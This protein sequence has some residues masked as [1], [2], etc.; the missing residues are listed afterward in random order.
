MQVFFEKKDLINIK[1]SKQYCKHKNKCKIPMNVN[2]KKKE[3]NHA[4]D[5]TNN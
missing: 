3:K 2:I 1:K 5:R 4:K